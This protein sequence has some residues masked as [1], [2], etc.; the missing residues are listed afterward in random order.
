[1]AAPI[2]THIGE[3]LETMRD[4]VVELFFVRVC[5]RVGFADAFGN[6]FVETRLMTSIFAILALHSS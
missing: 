3:A 4:P 5:F 6:H 2:S 1:M